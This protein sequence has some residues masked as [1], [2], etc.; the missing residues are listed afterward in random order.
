MNRSTVATFL[1]FALFGAP[2]S[3]APGEIRSL[4][5]HFTGEAPNPE[6]SDP[7]RF[8]A[9]GASTLFSAVDDA[10]GRELWITDGTGAGTRM[11][12]DIH[13]GPF[14]GNPEELVAFDGRVYFRATNSSYGEELWSS[15]GTEEG[16]VLVADL[17]PGVNQDGD[18]REL[19]VAGNTLFF[20]ART[21]DHGTELWKVPAGGEPELVVDL[22][23]GPE[24]S[25]PIHLTAMGNAIAFSATTPE[26]GWELVV[27]NGTVEG[28]EIHDVEPGPASSSAVPLHGQAARVLFSAETPDVGREL[29][30]YFSISDTVCLVVD[31]VPGPTGSDPREVVTNGTDVYFTA[32]QAA[33]PG[34]HFLRSSVSC[35]GLLVNL[36]DEDS[37][38][39]VVFDGRVFFES[40]GDL[41]A[42][43]GTGPGTTAGVIASPDIASFWDGSRNVRFVPWD[44][45]LWFK[46]AGGIWSSD[47]T[48]GGTQ[49]R[50]AC[51]GCPSA[52][53]WLQPGADALYAAIDDSFVGQ[54]PYRSTGG[55]FSLLQNA[56][57]DV[58]HSR[59][60]EFS[61]LG[62][63]VYF[64]AVTDDEGRELLAWDGG[65]GPATVVEDLRPGED[66]ATPQRLEVA[67]DHLY[68]RARTA[69]MGTH[70]RALDDPGVGSVFVSDE[71]GA[72]PFGVLGDQLFFVARD[73]DSVEQLWVAAGVGTTQLSSFADVAGAGVEDRVP[74]IAVGGQL[75]YSADDGTHGREAWVTDG[76]STD[77]VIDLE[78]GPAWGI[79]SYRA[80]HDGLFFFAGSDG[81]QDGLWSTDGSVQN[82]V[83]VAGEGTIPAFSL[84]PVLV[85][86]AYDESNGY[87][88]WA[89]D[90]TPGAESLLADI[91][92]GPL[93]GI[94]PNG[95]H[96]WAVSG[97][98]GFFQA[99]SAATG[100]E[101]WVTDGT[102]TGTRLL[103]DIA[104]GPASSE[105]WYV[106]PLP[107]GDVVFT[108]WSPGSGYELWRSDGT[109][110][111]TWLVADV[112]PGT[113]SSFPGEPTVF[114]DWVVFGA[115]SP[116][117]REPFA[118]DWTGEP[119]VFGDGFESGTTSAWSGS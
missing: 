111:G 45:E 71:S 90:G 5:D 117:G 97:G 59:P 26:T 101:L 55:F 7:V 18:P 70:L 106:T 13:P 48:S 100:V 51:V 107:N 113:E 62:D 8:V 110:S 49:I 115:W 116:V 102:P 1:L 75:F 91:N 67:G 92:P 20:S 63:R 16:T 41:W 25:S 81:T 73:E 66:D 96:N 103:R 27:S 39:L 32:D 85:L 6:D 84:G 50:H 34:K 10:H 58:G 35:S 52:V 44:G 87:E 47:G 118:Y 57:R 60:S 69:D 88:L 80:A 68:Y 2:I 76:A 15:D 64:P 33:G 95:L 78:P 83:L 38:D 61:V 98:R 23:S 42:T 14:H 56:H 82:T 4:G 99:N 11:L 94:Y 19:T 65:T 31:A 114:G 30:S 108:A 74:P 29:R 104:P 93:P 109:P 9:L 77:L 12:K 112:A 36:H 79:S 17:W 119:F 21:G 40:E 28:T 43:D 86:W 22:R 53:T 89:T 54:E 46:G 24:G 3:G 105:P 72:E 37:T